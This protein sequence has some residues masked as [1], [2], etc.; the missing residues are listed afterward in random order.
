MTP[1]I[2]NYHRKVEEACSFCTFLTLLFVFPECHG[3]AFLSRTPKVPQ[4]KCSVRSPAKHHKI[5]H[6]L[7]FNKINLD[8]TT[9]YT[10]VK[11]VRNG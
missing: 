7:N 4:N 11:A 8:Y 5:R 1:H 6:V 9:N 3:V 10:Y 2:F